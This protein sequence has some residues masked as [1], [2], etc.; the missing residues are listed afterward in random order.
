MMLTT[1]INPDDHDRALQFSEVK[2][3]LNKPL[4]PDTLEE[5]VR[6]YF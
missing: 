2:E 3:Y 1:S 4:L 5:I 6:K